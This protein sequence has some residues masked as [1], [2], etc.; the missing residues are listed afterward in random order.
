MRHTLNRDTSEPWLA[1]LMILGYALLSFLSLRW[2]PLFIDEPAYVDP[3]VNLWQG[4]GFVSGCWP[5][6]G[7]GKFWA[8]NVPLYEFVLFVWLKCFG[9]SQVVVR[10]LNIFLIAIGTATFWAAIRRLGILC[11]ARMRLTCLA[12]IFS[13]H[14]AM[15][16]INFG[17]PDSVCIPVAGM[18]LFAFSV[19]SNRVRYGLLCMSAALAPWAALPFALVIGLAG[20]AVLAAYRKRFVYEVGSLAL[21]GLL[22]TMALLWLYDSQGVLG[23]F[24]QSIA[25]HSRLLSHSASSAALPV[26]MAK[27][28]FGGFTDCTL[29]CLIAASACGWLASWREQAARAWRITGLLALAGVPLLLALPGVFPIYYAWF[30]FVPAL[31]ALLA[32]FERGF[33]QGKLL[34]AGAT[35][36]L[37]AM[38]LLGY[39]RV[40]INGFLHRSDDGV[41]KME[42]FVASVLH[43]GDIV[44]IQRGWYTAK[45]LGNRVYFGM[46]VSNL[47]AVEWQDV[48]VIICEPGYFESL[49]MSAHGKWSL[50]PENLITQNRNTHSFPISRFYRD[51][52][53][54]QTLVYRRKPQSDNP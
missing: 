3:A 27:H 47:S 11:T 30:A 49:Q 10:S 39:P 46:G 17:R 38:V 25:P 31:V 36:A 23:D 13:S 35:C 28:R 45:A 19:R 16:W 40:W 34:R 12:G 8:G 29:I 51:N 15:L 6:Q 52:P 26:N 50:L 32:I 7:Y 48:N 5:V 22:G 43:P 44:I 2:Y 53:T 18:A 4:Q 42:S 54:T 41:G 20:V 14:A 9:F 33:L 1:G 21:G 24:L 37:G